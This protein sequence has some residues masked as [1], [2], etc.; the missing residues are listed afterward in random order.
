[1]SAPKCS[2]NVSKLSWCEIA[3][4]NKS[5]SLLVIPVGATEQH[6][7]H[8]PIETDSKI[9]YEIVKQ[10]AEGLPEDINVLYTPV[11]WFG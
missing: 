11:I 3:E 1:M 8:L 2:K 4:I 7:H 5:N 10:S 6:G 9:V